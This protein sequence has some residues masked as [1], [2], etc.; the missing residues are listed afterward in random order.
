MNSY[1]FSFIFPFS[2]LP[3]FIRIV[4][5]C[6][7][8]CIALPYGDSE[9]TKGESVCVDRCVAKYFDV[10]QRIGSKLTGMSQAGGMRA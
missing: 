1:S 9:L 8:K 6:H 3:C 4:R 7:S 2:S 5:S 10:N